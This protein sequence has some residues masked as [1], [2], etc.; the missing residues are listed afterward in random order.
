MASRFHWIK[1]KR[2]VWLEKADQARQP[3]ASL[4][5]RLVEP[6]E[7]KVYFNGIPIM[8]LSRKDMVAKRKDMQI[9]FQD[10]YGS[11]NPKMTIANIIGEP[12]AIHKKI[13]KKERRRA[14][15][16]LLNRLAFQIVTWTIIRTN[17]VA[18]RNKEFV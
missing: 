2:S 16:E 3:L 13:G 4:F 11:L 10:P 9:I 1:V 15:S 8:G 7:G 17:S 5:L 18:D 6:T 14:S 12:F